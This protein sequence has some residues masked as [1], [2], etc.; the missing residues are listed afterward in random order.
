L[1][2]DRYADQEPSPYVEEKLYA[3]FPAPVDEARMHY[4]HEHGW[5]ERPDIVGA[6]EDDRF[7]ELGK[8]I[9]AT[10]RSD[11][12]SDRQRE[13]WQA[14]RRD[15]LLANGDLPWFTIA[16][17]HAQIGELREDPLQARREQ[18]DEIERF[19]VKMVA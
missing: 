14:W 12:L 13:R 16:A 18:L 15:R 3:G 9:V 10:E 7:R 19:L 11:L 4:F 17:A 8:R 5:P 2:A 6:L 1:L